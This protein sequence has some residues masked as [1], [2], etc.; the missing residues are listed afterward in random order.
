MRIYYRFDD[1]LNLD[2]QKYWTVQ[3]KC[4]CEQ[5]HSKLTLKMLL[6]VHGNFYHQIKQ[7]KI[8]RK[9]IFDF[10]KYFATESISSH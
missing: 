7:K 8:I 2:I 1:N 4:R 5:N 9:E 10:V 3:R 6:K